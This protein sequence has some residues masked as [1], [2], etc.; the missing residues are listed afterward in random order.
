MRQL[1]IGHFSQITRLSLKALRLY[2]DNGLLPPAYVDPETGYRFYHHEQIERAERVKTLR[3]AGMSLHDIQQLLDAHSADAQLAWLDQHAARLVAQLQQLAQFRIRLH[4]TTQTPV[5]TTGL[6]IERVPARLVA[7]VRVT[8]G[9]TRIAQDVR[10]AFATLHRS[11]SAASLPITGTPMIVY[12][13]LID[14]V[15][16]GDVEVCI[17]VHDD[18]THHPTLMIHRLEAIQV[19]AIDHQGPYDQIGSTYTRM[20]QLITSQG[21]EP[22]G[23]PREIY[24]N[25][26]AVTPPDAL[27]TR[28]EFPIAHSDAQSDAQSDTKPDAKA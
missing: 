8:T 24:L 13:D 12:H 18:M 3:G 15:S 21:L 9:L 5:P 19:A 10:Q 23:A 22:A 27:L 16:D 25:D 2:A 14:E 11:L 1:S 26:P 4:S 28:I 20:L 7:G 17:P 6:V